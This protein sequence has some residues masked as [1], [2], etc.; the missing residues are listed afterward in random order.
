MRIPAG[1]M[2][3]GNSSL[4]GPRFFPSGFQGN[5][6][7][8]VERRDYDDDDNYYFWLFFFLFPPPSF[9]RLFHFALWSE[10]RTIA[11]SHVGKKELAYLNPWFDQ[12]KIRSTVI[13]TLILL[14][15][16]AEPRPSR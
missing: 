14:D 7:G 5:N 6:P 4:N 8:T 12:V 15:V 10:H 9:L 13:F 3:V 11:C 2:T 16:L 1:T